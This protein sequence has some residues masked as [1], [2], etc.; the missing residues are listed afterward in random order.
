[1]PVAPVARNQSEL[2]CRV[3]LCVGQRVEA[4]V[5]SRCL[6][7]GVEVLDAVLDD[8]GFVIPPSEHHPLDRK[9]TVFP[10]VLLTDVAWRS[11]V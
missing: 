8:A 10:H 1:M 3:T 5:V 6:A 7:S 2:G 4:R 9:H 11:G